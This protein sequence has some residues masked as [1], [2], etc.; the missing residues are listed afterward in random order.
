MAPGNGL[1]PW[2][3]PVGV[4]GQRPSCC[5]RT[6]RCA[7]QPG[8]ASGS[9]NCAKRMLLPNE[10]STLAFRAIARHVSCVSSVWGAGLEATALVGSVPS[11][12]SCPRLPL[13]SLKLASFKRHAGWMWQ[14][15][16]FA[17]PGWP[18]GVGNTSRC[19]P[20]LRF[21]RAFLL[22]LAHLGPSVRIGAGVGKIGLPATLG[23]DHRTYASA[24]L[25][26]PRFWPW[27]NQGGTGKQSRF[28]MRC[29]PPLSQ[30]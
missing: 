29:H 21:L 27:V 2:G 14:V 13:S 4:S 28:S 12:A 16:P 30:S 6:G 23:G 11:A 26:S 25:E 24:W 18:I 9:A 1:R 15:D 17:A 22:L 10:L 5:K 8:Q 7:V 20:W 3:Q 19:F